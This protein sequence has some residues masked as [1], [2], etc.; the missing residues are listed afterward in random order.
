MNKIP[1]PHER[2][3]LNFASDTL[4]LLLPE[5]TVA[6]YIYIYLHSL[7]PI[8]CFKNGLALQASRKLTLSFRTNSGTVPKTL[9]MSN[10]I[11]ENPC[12]FYVTL[13][14]VGLREVM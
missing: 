1:H 10:Q 4:P 6:S 11:L 5:P 7:L 12:V 9:A 14:H 3:Q 8:I 2:A 13:C